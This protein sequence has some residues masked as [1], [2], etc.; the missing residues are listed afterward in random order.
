MIIKEIETRLNENRLPI[1]K[2]TTAAYKIDGRKTYNSPEDFYRL[3]TA[4]ELQDAAEERFYC[5]AL[6]TKNRIEAIFKCGQGTVNSCIVDVRGLFQK[7]LLFNTT[8]IVIFHNHPSGDCK[9]SE[10]DKKVTQRVY[11]GASILGLSMIDHIII[12]NKNYYSFFE[13][14]VLTR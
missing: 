9:P 8:N 3:A 11:N 10:E 1:L 6:N 5:I 4:L 13:N 12:G 14:N 7:A 2:E